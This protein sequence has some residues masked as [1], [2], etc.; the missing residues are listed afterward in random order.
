MPD[1]PEGPAGAASAGED[2]LSRVLTLVRLRGERVV[3]TRFPAT[4]GCILPA[5]GAYL[6]FVTAGRLSLHLE[7]RATP[8]LL[9]PGDLAV[10][11]TGEAHRLGPAGQGSVRAVEWAA[12]LQAWD[13]RVD[14]S[15]G[16]GPPV[17]EV[18]T[19]RCSFEAH[20]VSGVFSALPPLIHIP[21]SSGTGADHLA[22]IARYLLAE[23]HAPDSGAS[24]MISRLLDLMVIRALRTWVQMGGGGAGWLGALADIRISR[25]VAAI[26]ESPSRVWSVRDLARLAGMSRSGFAARFTALIGEPPAKYQARWRLGLADAMLK[27][28]MSVG[29]V[30]REIGYESESAFSRAFKAHFGHPPTEAATAAPRPPPSTRAGP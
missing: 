24:L 21:G 8:C 11:L 9:E 6:H 1:R 18:V 5:G 12:G 2:L 28:G 16:R 13:T 10:L 15:S 27:R 30:A 3:S 20:R 22:G 17:A 19:G 23:A 25:A 4:T 7:D 26:H 29:M 14:L